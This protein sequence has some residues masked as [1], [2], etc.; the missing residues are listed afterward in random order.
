M[1]RLRAVAILMPMHTALVIPSLGAPHL[2]ACLDAVAHLEPAPDLRILV[3]SAGAAAPRGVERFDVVAHRQR[4]GFAAA[5]NAGL[6]RLPE[7][8][9]AVALLNDD[10]TPDRGWLGVLVS[11]LEANQGLAAVQGTV[12]DDTGETVDGRGIAVNGRGLAVQVDRGTSAHPEPCGARP[13]IAVSATAALYRVAAIRG[14]ALD[15]GNIFDPRFDSYHEDVDLGLRLYRQG[16][17]SGWVPGATCRHLGSASGAVLGWRHPW[18]LLANPWRVLAG[19]LKAWSTLRIAPRT[20]WG[21]LRA[22]AR[23]SPRNLRAPIVAAAVAATLPALL[24]AG[25]RRRSP[26]PRL[27]RVPGDL[28]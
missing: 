7:E 3:V 19:N 4:L 15:E 23:M 18:W 27:D 17:T 24:V 28:S 8:I 21:E 10:A 26:G 22:V 1:T 6:R 20:L 16:W 11:A 14:A 12:T 2:H 9:G 25:W 13:R 5:V